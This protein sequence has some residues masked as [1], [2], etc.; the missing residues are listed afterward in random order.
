[1]TAAEMSLV[2]K[3]LHIN[4]LEIKAVHLAQNAFLPRIMGGLVV[5]ISDNATEVSY[6]KKRWGTVSLDLY[7]LAQEVKE[8]P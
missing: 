7:R 2:K 4:I 1:M 8:W 3:D 5:M 6:L